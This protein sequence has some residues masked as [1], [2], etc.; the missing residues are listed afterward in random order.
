MRAVWLIAA[1][2]CLALTSQTLAQDA[3]SFADIALEL[4]TSMAQRKVPESKTHLEALRKAATTDEEKQTLERLD[5]LHGYWL[6]FWKAVHE[7]CVKLQGGDELMIGD[8]VV[9]VVEYD[10]SAGRLILRVEGQNK[11]Y[12]LFDMPPKVAMVLAERV[13]RKGAPE[14]EA[15]IGAFLAMDGRGDRQLA[16]EAWQRAQRQG[17]DVAHLLPELNEKLP[18]AA[19]VVL[20]QLTPETARFLRPAMWQ[21]AQQKNQRWKKAALGRQG[22][23]NASGQLEVT[24][25][26]EIDSA[27]VV[28]G[29]KAPAN[30]GVRIY[31]SDLPEGQKFGLFN[32]KADE[33]A[34]VSVSLPKGVAKIEFARRDGKFLCS[35][36]DE[37]QEVTVHNAT[38]AKTSGLIGF[39]LPADAK[40][41]IAGCDFSQ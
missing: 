14:N 1:W 3:S 5:H 24:T 11:R 8:K 23:Q 31:L 13:L 29:R 6:D 30:F 21:L 27:W 33:A 9:S 40:V 28:F 26:G 2:A 25:P 17:I 7:G 18:T 12:T 35:I 39:S 36:N 16:R 22:V 37:V 15:F 41:V 4:R 32:E 38:A 34:D 19:T 10:A 20:P